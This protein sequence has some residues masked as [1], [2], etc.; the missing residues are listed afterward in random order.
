MDH[1]VIG[2]PHWTLACV[3]GELRWPDSSSMF[4]GLSC[5]RTTYKEWYLPRHWR[6]YDKQWIAGRMRKVSRRNEGYLQLDNEIKNT[7]SISQH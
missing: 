7:P 4:R 3:N 5:N 1:L 2:V 6:G